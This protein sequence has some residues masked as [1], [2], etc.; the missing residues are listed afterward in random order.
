MGGLRENILFAHFFVGFFEAESIHYSAILSSKFTSS[1][2][3]LA[4]PTTHALTQQILR[5]KCA[6]VAALLVYDMLLTV[7]KVK[8][9][10]QLR[11]IMEN[12]RRSYEEWENNMLV[13]IDVPNI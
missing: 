4:R 12:L 6:V 1:L 11:E 13:V 10:T 5:K 2:L 3:M 7:S 9:C 8:Q